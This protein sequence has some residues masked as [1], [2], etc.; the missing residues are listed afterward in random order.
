[1]CAHKATKAADGT[2]IKTMLNNKYRV[3]IYTYT[4]IY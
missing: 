4:H 2:T 3:N 1:M